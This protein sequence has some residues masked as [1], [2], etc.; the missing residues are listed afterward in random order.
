M[1]IKSISLILGALCGLILMP[2]TLSAAVTENTGTNITVTAGSVAE[3]S[4]VTYDNAGNTTSPISVSTT[5]AFSGTRVTVTASGTSGNGRNGVTI[6]TSGTVRLTDS[7]ITATLYG[8]TATGTGVAILLNNTNITTGS[9]NGHGVNLSTSASLTMTGGTITISGSNARGISATSTSAVTLNG[10]TINTVNDSANGI[11]LS[12]TSTGVLDNVT[13][14]TIG[15]SATG[16]YLNTS[17]TLTVNGG[18]VTTTGSNANAFYLTGASSLSIL[19]NNYVINSGGGG[20]ITIG[21]GNRVSVGDGLT[22]RSV[23]IGL[24]IAAGSTL[25]GGVLNDADISST[26]AS[27]HAISYAGSDLLTLNGG[28]LAVGG[29]N[30]R[31]LNLS[32]SASAVLNNTAVNISGTASAGVYMAASSTTWLN[33]ITVSATRGAGT[34]QQMFGVMG[35]GTTNLAVI[36][37]VTVNTNSVNG[38]PNS[39][40]LGVY[41]T[42]VSGSGLTVTMTGSKINT[43]SPSRMQALSVL[44]GSLQDVTVNITDTGVGGWITALVQCNGLNIDGLTIRLANTYG[45][46]GTAGY[47]M[48]ALNQISGTIRNLDIEITGHGG[49]VIGYR[50]TDGG[51]PLYIEN[52]RMYIRED[53]ASQSTNHRNAIYLNNAN[54]ML[55][56][57]GTNSILMEGASEMEGAMISGGTLDADH[58]L[59]DVRSAN[60][61]AF[62]F[63][64]QSDYSTTP[65]NARVIYTS[66]TILSTGASFEF[67]HTASGNRKYNADVYLQDTEVVSTGTHVLADIIG[68]GTFNLAMLNSTADGDIIDR[69]NAR[70]ANITAVSSI[71]T[72]NVSG[73]GSAKLTVTLDNSTLTGTT[74]ATGNAVLTLNSANGSTVTGDLTGSGSSTLTANLTNSELTGDITANGN[75]AVTLSGSN[76][77]AITGDI[78]G[79]GSSTLTASLDNSTFTGDLT[80]NGNT[81]ITLNSGNSILT[82]NL[83]GNTDSVLTATLTNSELTGDIT[84]NDNAVITLNSG[85]SRLSGDIN[86]NNNSVLTANLNGSE[87]TGNITAGDHAVVTLSGSNSV[88]TS[89]LSGG[90]DSSLTMTLNNSALVGKATVSDNSALNVNLNNGSVWTLTDN[91]TL[92]TLDNN[93]V[94][95]FETAAGGF[96][97]LTMNNLTGS[98]MFRMNVLVDNNTQN[99]DQMIVTGTAAGSHTVILKPQGDLKTDAFALPMIITGSSEGSF[100]GNT[101]VQQVYKG[102]INLGTKTARLVQGDEQYSALGGDDPNT[103][104]LVLPEASKSETGGGGHVIYASQA[105]LTAAWFDNDTLVKRMGELRLKQNGH[106][107]EAWVRSYGS[108]YNM[109]SKVTA[110]GSYQQMTYGVDIGADKAW[111]LDKRNVVYTGL[112]SGY[113]RSDLEFN[114]NGSD[115]GFD[116]YGLG[117]YA[118]WLHDT[119]WYADWTGRAA[120][121][122]GSF[123][124]RDDS[125]NSMNGSYNGWAAGTSIEFGRQFQFKDGWYAEP[126]VQASYVHFFGSD[127]ATTGDNAFGVDISGQDALQLRFGSLFGRTIKLSGKGFLQPYVKIFGVEQVSGGGEV[128]TFDGK[129]RPNTDGLSAVIG[130]GIIYQIDERNQ[131]HLDY[132]AR[133][134]DKFDKPFGIN[135]GYRRQF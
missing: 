91:S 78:V 14:S 8:V 76:G 13:V 72:G 12:N 129:Y 104:Y 124:S 35:T 17:S 130:A 56:F 31:A 84:A 11:Y 128:T 95:D 38:S 100:S 106:D 68:G 19:N 62:S 44:S 103:W 10:V 125:F 29:S 50:P 55:I 36:D 2:L 73:S 67:S 74:T 4:D 110:F 127:Y 131:L 41:N 26:G 37:D 75:A 33:N 45:V 7:N 94:V 46:T 90:N 108:Q 96:K 48:E 52:S 121:L 123:K 65:A 21:S 117:A 85:N 58:L 112:F 71:I 63:N 70:A 122:D 64:S 43:G 18:S 126:Q 24:N 60:S 69:G 134:A 47:A 20:I 49:R 82:G 87:F 9:A 120:Y 6:V 30:G 34:T 53:S 83:I 89:D 113:Q 132:E 59:L 109:G 42:V 135:L 79:S 99:S 40:E 102:A 80:G 98:G 16:I 97:T 54:Q 118:S 23:G 66:G 28:T 61:P 115:G 93:G 39:M 107:W 27:G 101:Q 114:Y 105:A 57:R 5:G 133:F 119:G 1:N 92:T 51:V 86:G 22:I 88:L 77:T 3:R 81:V 15:S 25:V 116:S 111:N 32:G